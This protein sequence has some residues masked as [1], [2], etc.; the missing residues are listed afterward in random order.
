ME[1]SFLVGVVPTA[2]AAATSLL[3][4]M[5]AET[6]TLSALRVGAPHEQKLLSLLAEA[7]EPELA[8]WDNRVQQPPSGVAMAR[9]YTQLVVLLVV[10]QHSPGHQEEHGNAI[11][12]CHHLPQFSQR[13]LISLV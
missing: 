10:G 13:V 1:Q 3:V 9:Y 11:G 2:M 5:A 7:L 12:T 8:M 4:Q 6:R